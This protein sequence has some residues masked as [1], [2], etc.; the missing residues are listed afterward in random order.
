M[1][2]KEINKAL[3]VLRSNQLI[4]YPTD[5]VWGIGCDATNE[6]AV[7]NIYK[8]KKR[9]PDKS[10]LVLVDSF[11]MLE[12][13]VLIVPTATKAYL[14]KCIKPT[15]VIYAE[16][17][18]LAKNML[19]SDNS[20]AIRIVQD[21]YCQ[22]LIRRFGKPIVSTSANLSG[23]PTPMSFSQIN[24]S[25][26]HSVDYIVDLQKEKKSSKTSSI[27]RVLNDETIEVIRD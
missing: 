25:I 20:I 11:E 15:T 17:H 22:N 19:A 24:A 9:D 18:K 16:P 3:D 27:I 14:A 23:E 10:L 26:L 12:K 7:A 6:G 4:L 21:E 5:T 8:I 2:S 1:I 13:Y